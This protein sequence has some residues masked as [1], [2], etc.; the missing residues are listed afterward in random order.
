MKR[1]SRDRWLAVNYAAAIFTSAFLLFQ[2]QPLIS[3][4]ILPWFGGSAAVWTTCLLFFQ[5][6]LFFG[7][8]YAHLIHARLNI[9][10]QVAVHLG[11]ILLA[12]L[13]SRVLPGERWEPQ[14]TE[15]PVTAILVI[16]AVSIGLPYF[17]LSATGPLLQAWFARSFPGESPYRLYAL[18]NVGSLLALLS[19]PFFFEPKFSVRVQ[20]QF[21]YLGFILYGL[22]CGYAAWRLWKSDREHAS[23]KR[24][25]KPGSSNEEQTRKK[26]RAEVEAS[27]SRGDSAINEPDDAAP[28]AWYRRIGWVLWPMFA[29]VVL[30][31]TTNHI[32]TDIAVMPFLWVVPLALYL[33][34]FIIAFDRPAW[35]QRTPMAV[36]VLAAIY[37][38]SLVHKLGV[39]TSDLFDA[40]TPG[41]MIGSIVYALTPVTESPEIYISTLAFLIV[42]F[43]AM[44][45]ICMVCH[46]ELYRQ[47]PNPRFLTSYYLLISLGGALGGFF[48]TFIAPRLFLT[49]FEWE[50]TLYIAC[51]LAILFLLHALVNIVFLDHERQE[52]RPLHYVLLAGLVLAVFLPSSVLLLDLAESL[53]PTGADAEL[54]IRNFFGTLAVFDREEDD[55]E[56]NYRIVKHGVITHGA[57][58][59]HESRRREPITYYARASG[60][61]RTIDFYRTALEGK[62]MRIGVVGLGSGT[63]AAYAEPGDTVTFYEI[64]SDMRKLTESGRWF[65]YVKEARERG[66]TVDIH[67]GDA[68]LSL[69]NELESMSPP[70]SADGQGGGDGTHDHGYH[71]IVLDAFSGD[72]VPAHL[73]TVEA[74]ELYFAHLSQAHDPGGDGAV[75]VHIS[76]RYLNLAPLAF[77]VARYY[78]LQAVHVEN[79]DDD[80]N[81][82]YRSHWVILT[83]N[84]RLAAYLKQ[85]ASPTEYLPTLIWTDAHSSLL[86]VLK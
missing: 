4:H 24:A 8:A 7:Y 25:S 59:T 68:R 45:S 30:M 33:L 63:L 53:Q 54:R 13:F 76:N 19:Y 41:R 36:L 40:G 17:V 64:D 32:S 48:V 2:V 29:S 26:V 58:Y 66:A 14:G 44:F 23:A 52:H 37:V 20:A 72:S 28:P 80:T 21:W 42:N 15:E 73:L 79:E 51:L 16:L 18:S 56:N 60:V 77:G 3:K 34:T 38:T 43:A 61:G 35:Y 11:L 67:M 57:Q 74:F 83:R 86:D 65:T 22:L 81:R 31:S 71:V 84:A 1:A 46:G 47:R 55:P 6:L 9:R 70:E 5:T 82:I 85:F 12:V 62:P 39:G 10:Q 75:L 49:Y 50:L 69:Q 27:A 78:D